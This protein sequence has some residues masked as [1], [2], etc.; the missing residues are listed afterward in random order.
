MRIAS[1][2][3]VRCPP[4]SRSTIT[5]TVST[6]RVS[7]ALTSLE[8]KEI[9]TELDSHADTCVIGEDTA[10]LTHDFE[11]PVRVYAFDGSKTT[12]ARTVTG[13]LGYTDPTNGEHYMLVIHQA[14]L[15]PTM[16]ANLIGLM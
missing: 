15:V 11:R 1:H 12:T 8:T 3:I 14:I 16:T 13:V 2:E 4:N 6:I 9:K 5:S 7:A 10:L